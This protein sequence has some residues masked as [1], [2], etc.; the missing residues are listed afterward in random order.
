V[1]LSEVRNFGKIAGVYLPISWHV[2]GEEACREGRLLIGG[3]GVS[4]AKF[5]AKLLTGITAVTTPS[6]VSLALSNYIL[7]S[8]R[9]TV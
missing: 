2:G 3:G 7:H 8:I 9:G 5:H 4:L 1:I 6:G